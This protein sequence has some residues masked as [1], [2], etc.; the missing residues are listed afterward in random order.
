M[1]RR[2]TVERLGIFL[3][4]QADRP[5]TKAA[6][7][8]A[9]TVQEQSLLSCWR[10]HVVTMLQISLQHLSGSSPIRHLA[11][12]ASLAPHVDPARCAVNVSDIESDEL[13]DPQSRA[14]EQFKN[15]A[16]SY[17]LGGES[18]RGRRRTGR[19][20]SDGWSPLG[21]ITGGNLLGIFGV[22]TLRAGLLAKPSSRTP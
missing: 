7:P 20:R 9:A 16:V 13:A 21:V 10:L 8:P 18:G 4:D 11:L 15:Q 19:S 12:L 17:N 2:V 22:A 3:Q 5:T 14:V 1:Q 6:K